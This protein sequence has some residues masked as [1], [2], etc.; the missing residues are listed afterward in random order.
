MHRCCCYVLQTNNDT[1]YSSSSHVFVDVFVNNS[2]LKGNI[3]NYSLITKD[4]VCMFSVCLGQ[5]IGLPT[6]LV[7]STEVKYRNLSHF[8][9]AEL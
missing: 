4:V 3:V 9:I 5:S 1:L 6:V 8:L 7:L 2:D